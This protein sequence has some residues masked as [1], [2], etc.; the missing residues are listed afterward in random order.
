MSWPAAVAAKISRDAHDRKAARSAAL[1]VVEVLAGDRDNIRETLE[2]LGMID[3]FGYDVG[4]T[5]SSAPKPVHRVG[6]LTADPTE[7]PV[8]EWA[9]V[10]PNPSQ[11]VPLPR[12]K[13]TTLDPFAA[14][15][16]RN[17]TTPPSTTAG[18]TNRST[19]RGPSA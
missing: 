9:D 3:Y 14:F 17:P 8:D 1:T 11:H 2:V 18:A 13:T 4:S 6:T 12:P 16:D 5:N 19:P 10:T 15:R 7:P